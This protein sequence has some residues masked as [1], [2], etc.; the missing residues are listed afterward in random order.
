MR[1]LLVLALI[2]CGPKAP[3]VYWT[4]DHPPDAAP[5]DPASTSEAPP[6]ATVATM[7]AT[8]P[9]ATVDPTSTPTPD[10]PKPTEWTGYPTID[11][12]CQADADCITSDTVPRGATACCPTCTLHTGTR[13]SWD[14]FD[15]ACK[16]H[17][18]K[19]CPPIN[20]STELKDARC[21]QKTCTTVKPTRGR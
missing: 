18:P 12:V 3:V 14:A 1:R 17:P 15:E 6:V 13:A 5:T 2:A 19:T 7:P 21:I 20:C 10:A 4:G 9:D 16:V 8:T 11:T